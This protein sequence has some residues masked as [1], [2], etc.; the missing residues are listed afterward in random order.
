MFGDYIHT[1]EGWT[2]GPEVQKS[3]LPS[4]FSNL[5]E[6]CKYFAENLKIPD[7]GVCT[8]RPYIN[9]LPKKNNLDEEKIAENDEC[10]GR[11]IWKFLI[12]ESVPLH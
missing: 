9:L 11:K 12:V 10:R 8:I 4:Y 7:C 2:K 5:G 1:F 3:G 6:F